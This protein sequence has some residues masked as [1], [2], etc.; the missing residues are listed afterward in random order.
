MSEIKTAFTVELY[1]ASIPDVLNLEAE[2]LLKL[3]PSADLMTLKVEDTPIAFRPVLYISGPMTGC[4]ENNYPAFRAC[5]KALRLEGW[6]VVDPSEHFD[7]E[8]GLPRHK[9]LAVDVV[10]LIEEC[11]GIVLL[12]YWPNSEGA[13]LEAQIAL[14]RGYALYRW[15]LGLLV[16]VDRYHVEDCLNA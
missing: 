8:L 2:R 14:D 1:H 3:L 10:Q 15:S 5:A 4:P 7:G 13:Q 16:S 12:D 6:E 9:Y 11:T